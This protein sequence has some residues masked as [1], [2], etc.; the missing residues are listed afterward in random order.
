MNGKIRKDRIAKYLI[1][2]LEDEFLFDE[3]SD[4][5]L[6]RCGLKDVLSGVPIPVKKTGIG[7]LS[8]LNVAKNMAYV[9]G[10]DINFRY[11]ESYTKYIKRVFKDGFVPYF[12]QQGS[13]DRKS[14]V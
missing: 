10:C 9:M 1:P 12:L 4:N 7:D 11:A 5:Y 8:A 13:V 6:N 2:K 3:F 14:V